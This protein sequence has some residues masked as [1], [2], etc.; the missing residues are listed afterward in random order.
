MW[1]GVPMG[2]KELVAV[3]GWPDTHASMLYE[4]NIADHTATEARAAAGSRRGARRAH[5]VTGVRVLELDAHVPARRHPQSLEPGTHTG[6]LFGGSAAAVAVGMMPICTGSDGGGSI[7]TPSSYSGLFG[8]KVS[9]GR[10]G[11]SGR[12]DVSL[13][14]VPGPI[15]RSVRDAARYVDA[16]AGPT[17]ID[18]TSLPKPPSYE[19]A[20]LSGTAAA[21]LR[22]LRAAWS[23]TLGYALCEPDVE[24][25]AHE[26]AIALCHDHGHRAGRCRLPLSPSGA[27]VEHPD[28][29]RR[30][31]QPS[32]AIPREPRRRRDAGLPR[33]VR[34]DGAVDERTAVSC[35]ATTLGAPACDRRRLR[36]SRPDPHADRG[37]DGV[38]G[39]G[40]AAAG[41]RRTAHRR[42][43]LGSVLRAVQHRGHA[44]GE[45]PGRGRS[46][47]SADR[48]AGGRTPARGRARPRV[49]ARSPKPSARRPSSPPWPTPR[50]NTPSPSRTGVPER[51]R[52]PP[53]HAGSIREGFDTL[54]GVTD[55]QP[56]ATRRPARSKS[57]RRKRSPKSRPASCACSSRSGCRVSVT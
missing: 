35:P 42:D 31:G 38:Q 48:D 34:A 19:E 27:G 25:R 53:A 44:R 15:C 37:H 36:R 21:R 30:V 6:R 14:S 22:G 17:D 11:D 23:A 39:R 12:F 51:S 33:R 55:T 45:H 29:P 7:R 26:A 32:R 24:K 28:E 13:L 8:F 50:P 10:V 54:L 1:A 57:P 46:R 9:F 2:V 18:P 3:E 43:G 47:R 5:D 16:I 4:N 49:A 56:R 52:R 20:L 40:P 41:D